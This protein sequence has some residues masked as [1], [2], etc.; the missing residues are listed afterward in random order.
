MNKIMKNSVTLQ[1]D[2]DLKY[3]SLKELELYKENS[4]KIIDWQVTVQI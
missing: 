4:I 1:F 3:R 2:N